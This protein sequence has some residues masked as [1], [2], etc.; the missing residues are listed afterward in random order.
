MRRSANSDS[1]VP[2]RTTGGHREGGKISRRPSDA[3]DA[4]PANSPRGWLLIR[5][6]KITSGEIRVKRTRPP[7]KLDAHCF[8]YRA[9]EPQEPAIRVPFSP[10][11]GLTQSATTLCTSC[12]GPQSG[13]NR[14]NPPQ[15]HGT[16][17]PRRAIHG[18]PQGRPSALR[19]AP[20][21]SCCSPEPV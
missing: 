20:T 10:D 13:C 7:Q 18:T 11:R 15:K 4:S 19:T 2:G 12:S 3:T 21:R 8:Q 14:K 5:R 16:V 9:L 1:P 6:A 17:A